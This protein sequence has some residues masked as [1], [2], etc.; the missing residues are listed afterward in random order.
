M[1]R[2]Y[3]FVP[4]NINSVEIVLYFDQEML[5][6][7][8]NAQQCFAIIWYHWTRGY[9]LPCVQPLR[10]QF[11][12]KKR[13]TQ[14]LVHINV[15]IIYWNT[16]G[17]FLFHL[18]FPQVKESANIVYKDKKNPET[19]WSFRSYVW[20]DKSSLA[21]WISCSF[22]LSPSNFSFSVN[23]YFD[24]FHFLF[25]AQ[26]YNQL[27]I[28]S[29]SRKICWHWFFKHYLEICQPHIC[30]I[31]SQF[32]SYKYFVSLNDLDSCQFMK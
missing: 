18:I 11:Q 1:C 21:W 28:N 8:V 31:W 16:V 13:S 27:A 9:R 29:F 14:H 22:L 2:F 6:W 25:T 3:S 4:I 19:V 12:N 15:T 32:V 23:T 20:Y 10:T 30:L 5:N 26:I 17:Y 7:V 24:S